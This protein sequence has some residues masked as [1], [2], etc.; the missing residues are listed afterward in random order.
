MGVHELWSI[1]EPVKQHVPLHSLGGKTL[2]VDLS[3]WV[4]EAQSVKK[5]VGVVNKPHLRNLFFRISTLVLMDVKLVFVTEGEAPKIKADTMIKRIEM[6]YGASSKPDPVVKAVPARVGRSYFR[7]V[8]KECLLMLECLGIPWVQAA[9]EAEA[10]CAYLNANGY[11]DGCITND[12]DVFLYGACTVYRNFTMNVKDPHVD[13]YEVSSI[14][15]RLGL[16][17]EALVGLAILL[18]CDYLPKGIP[19]VGRDQALKLI[20][21][22]KGDSL[23]QRFYQWKKQIDN[24]TLG[25][26]SAKK[27]THCTVCCHP[28]SAKVHEK[29]GCKLCASDR[30]CEPHDYDYCCPCEWHV[31]Q[32]EKQNNAAEFHIRKKASSV[33]GFPFHEVIQEFIR[34]KDKLVKVIKWRR[35][36][37]LCFQNYALERMEWPKFYACEKVMI[38]LTHYD[39]NERKAGREA[40]A[41]LQAIRILKTRVRNGVPCFEIE[42]LKPD[43]Y[44]FPDDQPQ[45]SSPVTIEEELLFQAAYPQIVALFHKE[46]LEIEDKKQK[47]KK[48]KPKAKSCADL[49][50]IADL[51]SEMSLKPV[52]ENQSLPDS[53]ANIN[54]LAKVEQEAG[55][56]S[57]HIFVFDPP[58]KIVDMLESEND[59]EVFT[60]S[61]S[62]VDDKVTVTCTSPAPLN[63]QQLVAASPN[64]SSLIC[65]LQLSNIDW[66]STSFSK[67][68]Q[69]ETSPA[70]KECSADDELH[71]SF[72]HEATTGHQEVTGDTVD[73]PIKETE[74]NK[75]ETASKELHTEHLRKLSLKERILIKNAQASVQDLQNSSNKSAP[76]KLAPLNL[77]KRDCMK[78]SF[79][80]S[81]TP[82]CVGASILEDIQPSKQQM[83]SREPSQQGIVNPLV[84]SLKPMTSTNA[85]SRP[86]GHPAPKSY[87]FIKDPKKI[88]IQPVKNGMEKIPKKIGNP[89]LNVKK[90]SVCHQGSSSSE[91]SDGEENRQNQCKNEMYIKHKNPSSNISHAPVERAISKQHMPKNGTD[92]PN[93]NM[94][95][96]SSASRYINNCAQKAVSA[97]SKLLVNKCDVTKVNHTD[98]LMTNT[99]KVQGSSAN[100]GFHSPEPKSTI[101]RPSNSSSDDDDSII[102]VDSP[103]PLAERLKLR[104]LQNS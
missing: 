39:M 43:G 93:A 100:C 63:A 27:T 36:S 85:N 47:S 69:S 38:L 96:S 103:L 9:G 31:A 44:T 70:L 61:P 14:K 28:G 17:R 80:S 11:V 6:R 64:V 77:H 71:G 12:G 13:C 99:N 78:P 59:S 8:L 58:L 94:M 49:D 48:T 76:I 79:E 50:D 68:P 51:L 66:D 18:G 74:G 24:G 52:S 40:D 34:N 7:T 75:T 45:E 4:C 30:Y 5:M 81:S 97:T 3:I 55:S 102:S 88:S 10:M 56:Q 72:C 1:L 23:L 92:A 33:G 57:D 87:T 21:S 67:S 22:L 37:L 42:W 84:I 91:N 95:T 20:E 62:C 19:G 35:P 25:A 29:K 26:K 41:Q 90:K 83:A 60:P 101:T 86:L 82:V 98:T 53:S 89:K 104:L 54:T 46:K 65:E 73:N 15:Q 2:A 16:D 32:Q